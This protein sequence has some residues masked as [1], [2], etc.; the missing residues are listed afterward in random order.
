MF[1]KQRKITT[2]LHICPHLSIPNVRAIRVKEVKI[3]NGAMSVRV[4][5]V[6]MALVDDSNRSAISMPHAGQG[7]VC[8][9]SQVVNMCCDVMH[10]TCKRRLER[11]LQLVLYFLKISEGT[12]G[13]NSGMI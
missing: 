9:A 3:D 8:V 5:R 4:P 13:M 12:I 11:V 2:I 7:V 10:A 6:T 1:I